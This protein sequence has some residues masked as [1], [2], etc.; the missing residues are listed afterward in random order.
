MTEVTASRIVWLSIV[1]GV[2][3]AGS[4]ARSG[5]HDSGHAAAQS[6]AQARDEPREDARVRSATE[7]SLRL[8]QETAE[9]WTRQRRCFSCHHQGLASLAVD[10]ARSQGYD[11]DPFW[12]RQQSRFTFRDF[13]PRAKAAAEGPG[14]SGGPITAAYALVSLEAN[15]AEPSE[16]TDALVQFIVRTQTW[17]GSWRIG[18]PDRPPLEASDFT[19]TALAVRA[20]RAFGPEALREQIDIRVEVAGRWLAGSKAETHEDRT[21]RLLGL[22]W[23]GR[24][25]DEIESAAQALLA[26]QREDGGWAQVVGMDSDA[27]ATGQALVALHQGA[28]LPVTDEAYRRG[29]A[30]LL[31][32]QHGDGSWLVRWRG[33]PGRPANEYFETGFPHGESQFISTAGTSWATMALALA[34]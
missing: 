5:A 2:W 29:V 23:T 28:D 32:T 25:A 22:K 13:L 33:Y 1:A 9:T 21:F 14:I 18:F 19:A 15:Q 31:D 26:N 8:L 7:K 12:S 20:L 27:Y 34:Q 10:V 30:F 4:A 6:G 11:I 3:L 16:V 17:D 24:A